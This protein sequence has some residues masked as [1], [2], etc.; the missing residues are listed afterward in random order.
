MRLTQ[1]YRAH[2]M[3]LE[4]GRTRSFTGPFIEGIPRFPKVIVSLG[5]KPNLFSEL[6]TWR[7]ALGTDD[8]LRAKT[9]EEATAQLTAM[10]R[11]KRMLLIIDDV[12]ES[13]H[14]VPLK[15]GG[16]GCAI[17]ITTREN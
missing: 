4:S 3:E 14:A 12:W 2:G 15:V 7:R 9:L 5:P 8:L 6:A 16:R 10:L 17:L 11:N 1:Q 13:E